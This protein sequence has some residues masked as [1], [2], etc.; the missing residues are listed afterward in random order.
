MPNHEEM[1]TTK[2]KLV[3]ISK[4]ITDLDHKNSVSLADGVSRTIDWMREVYSV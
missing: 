4:S 3:D 2:H 1:M